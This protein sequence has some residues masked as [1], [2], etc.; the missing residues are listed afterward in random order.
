MG[1][2]D[3]WGGGES[4]EVDLILSIVHCSNF[5][6][7]IALGREAPLRLGTLENGKVAQW[8]KWNK[9]DLRIV[10]CSNFYYSIALGREAPLPLDCHIGG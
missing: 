10:H 9:G 8:S 5:Y 2:V 6:Y 7:S 3:Q 1:A 4:R